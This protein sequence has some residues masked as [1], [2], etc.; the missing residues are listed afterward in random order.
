MTM[1]LIGHATVHRNSLGRGYVLPGKVTTGLD[2]K[3]FTGTIY[4][5]PIREPREFDKS[6]WTGTSVFARL[7]S[8]HHPCL[9]PYIG[10]E[11]EL[12]GDLR[13]VTP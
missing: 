8:Y 11:I 2:L 1:R 10:E 5:V 9:N 13:P 7:G 6:T 4:F 12:W 3:R